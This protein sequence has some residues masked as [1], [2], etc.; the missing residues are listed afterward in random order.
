MARP[1]LTLL[2]TIDP[3]AFGDLQIR[4]VTEIDGEYYGM[5][6][7]D[8]QYVADDV[9]IINLKKAAEAGHGITGSLPTEI[10]LFRV[11]TSFAIHENDVTGELPTQLGYL[12]FR[13]SDRFEV[14]G[15]AAIRGNVPTELGNLDA[16]TGSF[17]LDGQKG[18]RG[19]LP[20]ELG[21]L[22]KLEDRFGF[23]AGAAEGGGLLTG[24]LPTELGLLTK[25]EEFTLEGHR[26]TGPAPT[27]LGMLS[28][29]RRGFSLSNDHLGGPMPTQLGRFSRLQVR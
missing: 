27:E 13:L 6:P 25:V 29:L 17:V 5:F 4:G 20:T 16:L 14:W 15:N 10:G 12:G 21:K 7:K 28:N 3:F 9:T 11:M 23:A 22:S 26:F 24:A 18:L 1:I 2:D 8:V 19:T